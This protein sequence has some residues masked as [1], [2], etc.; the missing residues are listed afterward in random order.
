M[1]AWESIHI[2]NVIPNHMQQN[3]YRD[4]LNI[5][6]VIRQLKHIMYHFLPKITATMWYGWLLC[7]N[8]WK[9]LNT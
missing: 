9:S 6:Q 2:E 7:S 4:M 1:L 5:L 3:D 8:I